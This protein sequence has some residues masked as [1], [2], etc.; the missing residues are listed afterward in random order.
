MN[1]QTSVERIDIIRI[2]TACTYLQ[3]VRGSK[4]KI[5]SDNGIH[6]PSERYSI[7]IVQIYLR[8]NL[9]ASQY[10]KMNRSLFNLATL[11]CVQM[12]FEMFGLFLNKYGHIYL[13]QINV[14]KIFLGT[15]ML[16]IMR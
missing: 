8:C 9:D 3:Y 2:K 15:W 11:R 1:L 5:S 4:I 12:H 6:C 16:N 10:Y 14:N 7:K 13:S